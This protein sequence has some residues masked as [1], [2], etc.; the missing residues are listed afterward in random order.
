MLDSLGAAHYALIAMSFA[1]LLL[2]F[3]G[4]VQKK[5]SDNELLEKQ[6]EHDQVLAKTRAENEQNLLATQQKMQQLL[7]QEKALAEQYRKEVTDNLQKQTPFGEWLLL[8][9]FLQL[10]Q[11]SAFDDFTIYHHLEYEQDGQIRQVDFFIVSPKG[12]FV[13]ES[14][15]WKGITYIFDKTTV[16]IFSNTSTFRYADFGI[17]GGDKVRVFNAK[18]SSD[19]RGQIILNSYE[20]PIAQ[21]RQYSQYLWK[22]LEVP[23]VYNLVVFRA[24][25]GYELQYNNKAVSGDGEPVG[26]YTTIIT[27]QSDNIKNFLLNFKPTGK[28]VDIDRINRL[29]C[30]DESI[31]NFRFKIDK[32][33]HQQAPFGLL[34]KDKRP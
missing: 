16:N 24:S 26:P 15:M 14:K 23:A 29:L 12:L 30:G 31:F 22:K 7:D 13:I 34:N 27:D 9:S 21:A 5:Q 8:Q 19:S 6:N 2:W 10:F 18:I 28:P 32:S 25:S 4:R 1:V 33:N 3:V 20:N 17:G 11:E